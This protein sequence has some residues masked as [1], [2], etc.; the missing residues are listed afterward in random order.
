MRIDWTKIPEPQY[1]TDERSNLDEE[2]EKILE[3]YWIDEH[4][5]I[6]NCRDDIKEIIYR[7][8][9]KNNKETYKQSKTKGK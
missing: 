4:Y 3:R 5:D 8:H 1:S 6:E 7:E 2:I 9:T